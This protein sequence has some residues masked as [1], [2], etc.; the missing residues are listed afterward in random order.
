MQLSKQTILPLNNNCQAT[1]IIYEATIKSNAPDYTTK[2]YIGTSETPFKFRY[3][4]YK[5]SFNTEKY[6]NDTALSKEVWKIK[7]SNNEPTITW[8]IIKRTSKIRPN[9]NKCNLCLHEKTLILY[10]CNPNLLN[11]RNEIVSKCRHINKHML[12]IFDSND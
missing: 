2:T 3:A 11:S 12:K 6:K 1:N 5:K 8:K 9:A 10:S 4:N 7:N